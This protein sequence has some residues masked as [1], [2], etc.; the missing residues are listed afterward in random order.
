MKPISKH[1]DTQARWGDAKVI[2][3]LFGIHRTT[4]YRL[5][6][7]G[8]IRTS[9]LREPG[10]LRGKRLFDIASVEALLESRAT[11]GLPTQIG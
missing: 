9:S 1:T 4:L 8:F 2:C 10:T 5:V 7:N 11:G 3:N 6:A